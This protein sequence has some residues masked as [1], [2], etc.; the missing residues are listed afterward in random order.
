MQDKKDKIV[1][2]NVYKITKA[3]INPARDSRTGRFPSCVRKVNSMGDLI[4]LPGDLEND[5]PVIAE[6]REIELY[7]GKTFDLNDKY[8]EAEW[9][10]IQNC[11]LIAISRDQKDASGNYIID[12][13]SKRYGSAEFYVEVPG[14]DVQKRV[15]KLKMR[16]QA[17]SLIFSSNSPK[18]KN[19]AKILGRDMKYSTDAEVQEFLLEYANEDPEKV[20]N[21]FTGDDLSLRILLIDAK[22]KQVITV[23]HGVYFYKTKSTILGSNDESALAWMK[24]PSNAALVEHIRKDTYGTLVYSEEELKEANDKMVKELLRDSEEKKEEMKENKKTNKK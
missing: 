3:I 6:N 13:N 18:L 10:A 2:R 8:Q 1:I 19:I 24:N 7:D 15:S 12:G 9:Q 4:L 16:T 20:I 23:A 21:I 14:K 5:V 11:P 17:N 22:E